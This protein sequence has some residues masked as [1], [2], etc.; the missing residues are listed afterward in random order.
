MKT[1]EEFTE[2]TKS[3]AQGKLTEL[4]N[5]Y[6]TQKQS[7]LMQVKK[8]SMRREEFLE[9][10]RV[11]IGHYYPMSARAQERLLESFEQYVFGYSILSPLI[12]DEEISDI[13]V[14]AY[15]N[16]RIKRQGKRMDAGICFSSENFRGTVK[17]TR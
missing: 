17:I 15:D 7:V 13:R 12:D 11:H 16:V 8:G 9:E 4:V 6:L 5:D 2:E 14:V 1:M 10:V 3:G